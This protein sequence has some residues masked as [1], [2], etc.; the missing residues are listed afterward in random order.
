LIHQDGF[1]VALER[2]EKQDAVMS[3]WRW[4][5]ECL[6][7]ELDISRPSGARRVLC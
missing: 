5:N 2:F 7:G 6:D 3:V 4:C 1:L